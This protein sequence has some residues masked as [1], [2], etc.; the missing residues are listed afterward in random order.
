M[1]NERWSWLFKKCVCL[2]FN[3]PPCQYNQCR[4]GY[5]VCLTV[6]CFENCKKKMIFKI[7]LSFLLLYFLR[8]WDFLNR[9]M[10]IV[11]KKRNCIQFTRLLRP[12]TKQS[13][14][15]AKPQQIL[16]NLPFRLCS[17]S[18]RFCVCCLLFMFLAYC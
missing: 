9:L 11:N 7:H 4:Y 13:C 12:V 8:S 6:V 15:E 1:K 17:D 3:A 18:G 2:T 16:W 14:F 5:T 10:L